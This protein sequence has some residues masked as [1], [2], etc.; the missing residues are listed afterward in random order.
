MM[1]G[2]SADQANNPAGEGTAAQM[3]G[4]AGA[5][6]D[7]DGTLL[8][9]NSGALWMRRERRLGRISTWQFLQGG[10][11]LVAYRVSLLDMDRVM[12]KALQTVRGLEEQTVKRWTWEWFEREVEQ[13]LAPGAPPVIAEHRGQ[14]HRL[15]LA[16]SSSPY[17]SE[18]ACRRFGL[19]DFVSSRYQVREGRLTGR[20]VAPACYGRGKL[21]WCERYADREGINLADSYFYTDSFSDLPLLERVGHPRAVNPDYRLRRAARQR[22]WP[23]LDWRGRDRGAAESAGNAPRGSGNH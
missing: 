22:G 18:I 5:F 6:F 11:Y 1:R 9:V 21:V 20:L 2:M 15:V 10:F 19:D 4:R 7:L 8:T 23:I 16:T 13:H 14:G 3:D 17:E 12:T